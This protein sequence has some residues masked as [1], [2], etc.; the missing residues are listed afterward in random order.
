M[1]PLSSR[2]RLWSAL[3]IQFWKKSKTEKRKISELKCT[4]SIGTEIVQFCERQFRISLIMG[5]SMKSP[6]GLALQWETGAIPPIE[7]QTLF[8]MFKTTVMTKEN[9]DIDKP[10][11]PQ[12]TAGD[13][14]YPTVSPYDERQENLNEEEGKRQRK[15]NKER[16]PKKGGLENESKHFQQRSPKIDRY[17]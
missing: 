3:L 8:S 7:W 1:S 13:F 17:T 10:L 12:L 14:I 9:M 16:T 5:R 6:I 15:T 4:D 11:R 2:Y